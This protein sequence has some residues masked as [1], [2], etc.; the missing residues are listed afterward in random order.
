MQYAAAL[1]EYL[2][3]G[4]ISLIW[5]GLYSYQYVDISSVNIKDYKEI[6]VICTF[7]VAY[8]LGIYVD[9]SSSYLLKRLNNIAKLIA[10]HVTYPYCFKALSNLILGTSRTEPYKRSAEILSYSPSDIIKTME[11]YVSRDRIAR[12]MA[13]NSFI[14]GYISHISLAGDTRCIAINY[15]LVIFSISV[16]A[17]FRLQRLSGAFKTQALKQLSQRSN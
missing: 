12:G 3:T 16:L 10:K 5:I 11:A 1:I 6:I 14:G 8:V 9:V 17:W 15:C 7:P 4:L 13:L 2:I